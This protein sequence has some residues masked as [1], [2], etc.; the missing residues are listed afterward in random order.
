MLLP[1]ALRC[2]IVDDSPQ[3]LEAARA[4]LQREGLSVVGVASTTADAVRGVQDL[5]PDVMLIDVN[6]G[7]ESGL[8][9][10]R[11]IQD[12]TGLD[13]SRVILISTRTE[14]DL[15]DLITAAPA[16]AFLPKMRL[17]AG[18]IHEILGDAPG[19]DAG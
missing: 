12:E 4:L 3:F 10:A 6:L 19:T 1:M 14:D 11:R 16:A 2:F 8:D 17:S 15:A 5:E 9:L 18:A 7:N 13:S